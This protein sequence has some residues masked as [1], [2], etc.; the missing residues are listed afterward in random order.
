MLQE[1]KF[2]LSTAILTIV[3]LATGVGAVLN[4]NAYRQFHLPDDGVIWVNHGGGVQ[5]VDVRQGS[6]A[7]NALIH[8]GDRLLSINNVRIEKET[9]VA[10]VLA[11]IKAWG[12]AD[13]HLLR[14]G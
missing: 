13:Y 2:Q 4:F 9:D 7:D 6:P 8:P 11:T 1:L 10:A 5:A 12:K 14:G 3:T